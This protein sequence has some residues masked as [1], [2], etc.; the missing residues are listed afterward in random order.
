MTT[1]RTLKLLSA[2]A[3][4]AGLIAFFGPAVAQEPERPEPTRAD[5]SGSDD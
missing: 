2:V 3:V 4:L 1:D 5:P